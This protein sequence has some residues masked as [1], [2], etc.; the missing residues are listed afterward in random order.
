VGRIGAALVAVAAGAVMG[1][2]LAS[3]TGGS[4]APPPPP[5]P[6]MP[7]ARAE[8]LVD[9]DTGKVLRAEN[10]HAPMPP[11]SLTKMLTAMIAA[12][13]LPPTAQVPVSAVAANAFP[14]KVG[15]KAGQLWPFDVTLNA[16]LVDSANDA[17]YALA[18]RVSG[19]LAG[20]ATTMQQAAGQLGMVDHPRLE[21]PAGLDGREGFDSGNL[22]SAFDLATAGRDLM[23]N[24]ALA[25]IVGTRRY[26]FTGPDHIVYSLRNLNIYFLRVYPGAI[27]IKTGLTDAAGFCVAEEA[28]RGGR[29]MLAVVLNGANSYTTAGELLDAGFATPVAAEPVNAQTLPPVAEPLPP[30]PVQPVSDAHHPADPA[31]DPVAVAVH[32]TSLRKNTPALVPEGAAAGV[33]AV[34][35]ILTAWQLR[36]SRRS[37][38]HFRR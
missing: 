26:N 36:R 13:Y 3:A 15:M 30:R 28:E 38:R 10:E 35:I 4:P 37:H 17:A 12:D 31:S 22:I 18:E 24:P 5:T 27:G 9:V 8:I 6:A 32:P 20:F 19:S 25:A 2:P 34:A 29:K 33:L 7:V 11:G 1:A 23:A 16:L 21:D 14:D